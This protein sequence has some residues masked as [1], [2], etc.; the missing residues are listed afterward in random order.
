MNYED[1]I[2][3]KTHSEC[4]GGVEPTFIPSAA[5]DFQRYLIEWMCRKGRA[6]T[7]ADCGLG[8]TII[9]LAWCENIVRQRNK[10]V[11]LLTPLAVVGQTIKE[12]EKFGMQC[13]RMGSTGAQIVA[14]NY[15]QLHKLDPNDYAGVALDESSILKDFDGA[16]KSQITAFM[17]KMEY[18]ALFTATGAPNDYIELGTSSEALGELGHMDMLSRFFRNDQNNTDNHRHHIT[19]GG[20]HGAPKWRFKGHAQEP[21][22]RWVSSWARACRKPSDIG[23]DDDRFVLP[24]LTETE[25]VVKAMS[26]PDGFLFATT[27]VG[28]KEQREERR[29][30]IRERCERMASLVVDTGKPAI[31]W[32]HLNDEG[33]LLRDMIP[34][35]VQVSGRDDDDAKVAAFEAFIDGG[36]RVLIT[37]PKIGAWGLNFQH[38][39]HVLTFASHSYEQYYQSVRRCWRFGQTEPVRVDIVATE[40]EIGIR[41]NLRRKAEQADQ[42]FTSL[43]ANMNQAQ[44]IVQKHNFDKKE[45]VP[46]WL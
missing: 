39:A 24:E 7:F 29:R 28:L 15:E 36:A 45:L 11:L 16:R 43:I 6:A 17:R 4:T 33:D 27:A 22:W 40:S 42:M 46:S 26:K 14:V 38:C 19:T 21:F 37:K 8:K 44:R 35:S 34:G 41:D 3:S 2:Q 31:L 23:F 9:E 25:H 20:N 30:T 1:F 5:F 10:L 18:R 13:G 12:A 32:C